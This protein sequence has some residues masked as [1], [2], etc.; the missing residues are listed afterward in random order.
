MKQGFEVMAEQVPSSDDMN[1]R[2]VENRVTASCCV[3][4]VQM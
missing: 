3:L 4:K 2:H 1:Y